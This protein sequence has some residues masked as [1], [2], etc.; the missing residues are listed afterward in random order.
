[1]AR[2]RL[3]SRPL[4]HRRVLA[5]VEAEHFRD[6]RIMFGGIAGHLISPEFSCQG[7]TRRAV[8]RRYRIVSFTI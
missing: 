7:F 8:V 4:R 1:L 5:N 2:R 3:R 6:P